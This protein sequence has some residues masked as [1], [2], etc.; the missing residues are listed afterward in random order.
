MDG[1]SVD[2]SLN[3]TDLS[4]DLETNKTKITFA[5]SNARSLIDKLDSV[6]TVYS[7]FE[8]DL[9]GITE[10][11]LKNNKETTATLTELKSAR[12]IEFIRKD[13]SGRRGGGVAISYDMSKVKLRREKV[14]GLETFE[15]V[16]A[17]GKLIAN[18]RPLLVVVTYLPPKLTAARLTTFNEALADTLEEKMRA[19]VNPLVIFMGD[20]NRKNITPA[21]EDFPL[22]KRLEAGPTRGLANLD[23]VHVNFHDNVTNFCVHDPLEN[24][25]G[26]RSN[27]DVVIVEASFD[28]LHVFKKEEIWLRHYSVE[29]ESQFGAALLLV[30][31]TPIYS[32]GPSEAANFLNDKLVEIRDATFPLRKTVIKSTDGEWMTPS[33]RRKIRRKRRM[34]KREGKTARWKSFE[35]EVEEQVR[36]AKQNYLAKAKHKCVD[37][38]SSG[39]FFKAVNALKTPNAPKVWSVTSLF[40]P[41]LPIPDVADKAAEFFNSISQEYR[42]IPHPLPVPG[43]LEKCPLRHEIAARLKAMKKPKSQVNGDIDPRLATKFADVISEPLHHIF[44]GVYTNA[45]WPALWKNETVTLIPKNSAPSSLS[46]V[47]YISCTPLFSKLLESYVL[48]S[49]RRETTL[50]RRQFGGI[51]G[52]SVNHYL[53]E[54][55]QDVLHSLE[56]HRAS[57][58]ITAVDYEKAFNRLDHSACIEALRTNGASETTVQLVASFLHERTMQVKI[59]QHLSR[60]RLVPGGSPQGSILGNYLFCMTT[61]QLIPR[62]SRGL[63][64][65]SPSSPGPSP[66]PSPPPRSTQ[67]SGSGPESDEEVPFHFGAPHLESSLNST[68]T[69][70]RPE[71]AQI[72]DFLGVPDGWEEKGV[73]TNVYVDDFVHVE[74]V[75]HSDAIAHFTTGKTVIAPQAEKTKEI[76]EQNSHRS[77]ELGMRINP[78]K[79][80]MICISASDS[81]VQAYFDVDGKR[82]ES[83]DELKVLGFWF[84]RS[85]GAGTHVQKLVDKFRCRLWAMRHL[86]DSGMNKPD[87]LAVYRSILLPVADFASV[88]YGPLLTQDQSTT[89]EGLQRRAMKIVYDSFV[90]YRLA[91][92]DAGLTTLENRRQHALKKFA[93]K[94]NENER[95]GENWFPLRGE[96]AHDV[97]YLETLTRTNRFYKSPINTMRRLL[98]E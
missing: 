43:T 94:C 30:D 58:V 42:G 71:L 60:P 90:P 46:E 82:I 10:T 14:R 16:A 63:P 75:R 35:A 28:R 17:S 15:V 59:G 27:H 86:R 6:A 72:E 62:D 48:D 1:K 61:N 76:F 11:W 47:R 55:W 38:K 26:V 96:A 3:G 65:V 92:E 89:L 44:R 34:Y 84:G 7:E 24:S 40:P 4:H 33:L 5:N 56:D 37:A 20:I 79:T 45:S 70:F 88:T 66:P 77:A 64:A 57:A 69:S 95:Y 85:P 13:R 73:L 50:S 39:H 31:W 83:C 12:G 21:L 68:A 36:C 19:L 74:K 97:R 29:S 98:N 41:D 9:F 53:C 23:E 93:A 78:S 81:R 54:L 18:G 25:T 32:L 67:P 91:L 2:I 22:I 80:S 52:M 49:L 8:L 87:L 51:K